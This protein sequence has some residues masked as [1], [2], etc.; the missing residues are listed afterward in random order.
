ML[1][2]RFLMFFILWHMLL[3]LQVV[4]VCLNEFRRKHVLMQIKG[5]GVPSS[6][7]RSATQAE[8]MYL[9]HL[10]SPPINPYEERLREFKARRSCLKSQ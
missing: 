4:T 1:R 6:C 8:Y 10:Y 9:P 3:K 2:N 5:L 7:G